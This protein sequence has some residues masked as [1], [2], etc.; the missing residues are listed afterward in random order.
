MLHRPRFA[1]LLVSL[2]LAASACASEPTPAQDDAAGTEAGE[3]TET[4]AEAGADTDTETETGDETGDETGEVEDPMLEAEDFGCI[5]EWPKVRRFRVTNVLGDL[6]ATLA[7]AESPE[8]GTYPVGS[9]IQLVPMEAMLK[10]APGFAP[11]SND[12]EFFSLSVDAEGT[13]ILARGADEVVN[14]F[15]GNCFDCHSK[16]EPQW[17]LICE[18]DHGCDP[19]PLTA[20]QFEALQNS[21]PRCP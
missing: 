10:R 9:L 16:A 1:P 6:D 20:E 11:Q 2:I 13:E 3:Q 17:D 12:W 5:L 19:L 8:G 14:A 7:V 21:D 15:G 4:E 18:Q